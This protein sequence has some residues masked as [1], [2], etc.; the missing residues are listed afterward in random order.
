MPIT[1]GWYDQENGILVERITA[2]WTS[3][4]YYRVIETENA[5]LAERGQPAYVIVDAS[6]T[7]HFPADFIQIALHGSKHISPHIVLSVFVIS[8]P[9][10]SRVVMM[11]ASVVPG[12]RERVFFQDSVEAAAQFIYQ[13][14]QSGN[15]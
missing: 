2:V 14:I 13:H 3:D 8:I 6:Q 9:V 11:A 15:K 7:S 10:A 4:A 1:V 12:L 5:M